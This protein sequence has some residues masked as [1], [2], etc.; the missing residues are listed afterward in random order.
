MPG[1]GEFELNPI[2]VDDVVAAIINSIQTLKNNTSYILAGANSFSYKNLVNLIARAYDK[3]IK[4]I[5]IPLFALKIIAFVFPS[6]LVK[7]QTPRLLVKK[8]NDIGLARKYLNFNPR[9][10]EEWVKNLK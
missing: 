2:F 10:F 8:S 7:D 1:K 6:L 3:K 5:Y 9:N 4:I